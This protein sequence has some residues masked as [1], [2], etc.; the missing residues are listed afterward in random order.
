MYPSDSQ[1]SKMGL[2]SG[3][4]SIIYELDNNYKLHSEIHLFT[5]KDKILISDLDGTLTRNDIGGLIH[6]VLG[7][8]YLHDGYA[9]M[10]RKI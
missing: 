4:N 1:I 8:D 6:N 5:Y 10:I 2:K 9:E 3:K 7:M